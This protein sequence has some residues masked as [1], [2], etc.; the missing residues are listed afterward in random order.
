VRIM[1]FSKLYLLSTEE[2][3]ALA[4]SFKAETTVIRAGNGFGKSALLK[5]LYETFGAEPHRIDDSW[6][7]ANVISAVDFTI[8]G[9]QR[10]I[11]KFAGTYTVFDVEGKR[12]FQTAS[13]MQGLAPYLAELLDFRLL[14]TD[15]QQVVV[16]PPPAYAFAPFYVDQDKSWSD[17]W[18][19]F[20]K[21]F[22]PRSAATLADYHLGL[23]PNEYYVA[24]SEKDRAS[25]KLREVEVRRRGLADA[26]DHLREIESEAPIYY[27]LDDYYAETEHLLS[28]SQRLQAE[29]G[30]QWAKLAELNDARSVWLAQISVTRAALGEAEDVFA[31]AV[32]HS[33]D[34]ECPTCGEHYTNDI[35]TRFNIAADSAALIGV[36]R[37]AQ[38]QVRQLD[39]KIT[40]E[41]SNVREI[42]VGI[43]RIQSI[44]STRRDD[45]S[46]EQ[47]V[48]AEGRNAATRV[49]RS[50]IGDVDQEIG[51]LATLI[52]ELATQMRRSLDRKRSTAIRDRFGAFLTTF[53]TQLDVRVGDVRSKAISRMNFARGSEGPRGL[54]AYY[55]ACLHTAREFGSS[56]FCPLVIDAPN[57]QGQD[58]VHLP[59]IISFLVKQRPPGSQLILGVEE[60]AGISKGD[61]DIISVGERRNQLLRDAEFEAVSEHLRPHMA[62]LVDII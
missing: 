5:S 7:K 22:L 29:Q 26:I 54:A 49:L 12:I 13:V 11:L 33:L 38:E 24:Q 3:R 41:R 52:R 23:K 50:R 59:A 4:V 9:V 37:N 20:T 56:A 18:N 57:Q 2:R 40:K 62:Q 42:E 36:M 44:L 17:A 55:Y 25:V 58:A 43:A 46:F 34:V 61:A 28:E 48:A 10:T 35:A 1:R 31:S 14:M 6:R 53:A 15:Q 21:M 45:L 47:V 30:G 39:A 8:D 27:S 51:A 16:T 60:P 32:G 19:S